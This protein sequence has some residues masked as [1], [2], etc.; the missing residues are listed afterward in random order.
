M[1]KKQLLFWILFMSFSFQY[2]TAQVKKLAA[3][4][5]MKEVAIW[6][7]AWQLIW[8]KDYKLQKINHVDFILFDDHYVYTTLKIKGD[9]SEPIAGPSLLN[10][11]MQWYRQIHNDSLT[12]P[13]GEKV[14][15]AMMCFASKTEN[16]APF[17]VMPLTSYWKTKGV[18]DHGIGIE[19]LVSCVFLHEFGHTQQLQSSANIDVVMENYSKEHPN[20]ILSDD[21][22]QNYYEKDSAYVSLFDNEVRLFQEAAFSA[23]KSERQK[24][25][26]LAL[27]LLKKR[28]SVCL[29]K[30]KRNIA[31]IDN[32]FLTLEGVGQYNAFLWLT[33]EKGRNMTEID[34]RK[35]LKT[36]WWSQEEGLDVIILLSRFMT[37]EKLGR[38]MFTNNLTSAI[39]LLKES[40]EQPITNK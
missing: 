14:K 19:N 20:D 32:Y 3:D 33:N 28:Q 34:A 23:N 35:S 24:K 15:V 7:K 2:P 31:E 26:K 5:S 6:F 8:A 29:E 37:R 27:S 10:Q 38:L 22:M 4:S 40:V 17:F 9:K 1:N 16:G 30:D 13:N 21:I 39:T 12:F 36:K 11:T 25:A 18:G